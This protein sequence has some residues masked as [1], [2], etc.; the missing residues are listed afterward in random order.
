MT[1]D[2]RDLLLGAG[3][4]GV[5]AAVGGTAAAQAPSAPEAGAPSRVKVVDV[6]THMFS[7]GWVK[8]IPTSASARIAR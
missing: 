7:P 1:I 6:H 4:L 2:R 3:A 5:A 8:R